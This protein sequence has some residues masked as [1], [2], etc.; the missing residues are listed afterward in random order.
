MH[1]VAYLL[2]PFALIFNLASSCLLALRGSMIS[3]ESDCSCGSYST[4]VRTSV[5]HWAVISRIS[6]SLAI[7]SPPE[8]HVM[9]WSVEKAFPHLQWW[10]AFFIYNPYRKLSASRNSL[11]F[12]LKPWSFNGNTDNHDDEPFSPSRSIILC[13]GRDRLSLIS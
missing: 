13:F 4:S 9:A 8:G 12:K 1:L 5:R 11:L 3:H 7:G 6:L 10:G 2:N